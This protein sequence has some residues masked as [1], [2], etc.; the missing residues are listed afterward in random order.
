LRLLQVILYTDPTADGCKESGGEFALTLQQHGRVSALGGARNLNS[1]AIE[2]LVKVN[3]V[4]FLQLKQ[5]SNYRN[6]QDKNILYY[7]LYSSQNI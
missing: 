2:P 7:V 3:L 6:V 4:L 1:T 5:V